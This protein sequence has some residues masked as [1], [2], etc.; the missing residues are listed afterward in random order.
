M[1]A[2]GL[3]LLRSWC[4]WRRARWLV[5]GAVAPIGLLACIARSLERPNIGVSQVVYQSIAIS[6]NRD[7]DILFLVDKSPTMADEQQSL[8]DNF[9]RF[10]EVLESIE[11]GLPNVHIGVITQDIGAGGFDSGGTCSG[12]GDAGRLQNTPRVAGCSPPAGAFIEDIA[13]PDGTRQRNYTGTLSDTF[14]CIAQVGPDGCGFEQHLESLKRALD[15]SVPENAGFL[16]PDAYLGIIILSDE[17]DCSAFDANVFAPIDGTV[18][19]PLGPLSDFRCA[20]F[21]WTCDGGPVARAPAVYASCVPRQDS[22]FLNHPQA[23][24][25]FVKDLKI[26]PGLIM[27]ATIIGDNSRFEIGL[28][29]DQRMNPEV[30]PSC[31]TATQ[32]A[33]PMPRVRYFADQFANLATIASICAADFSQSLILIAQRLASIIGNRCLASQT[34]TTD[35]DPNQPGL[36]LDCSALEVRALDSGRSEETLVPRCTMADATT[37]AADAPSP[38]WYVVPDAANCAAAPGQLSIRIHPPDRLPPPR[39]RLALQC[40]G[41]GSTQ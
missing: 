17:D 38:C 7:L 8:A 36:Q 20:E 11:G 9:P 10:I 25:D 27:V 24:A 6:Q 16:R 37:P 30:K 5:L 28:T 18:S 4:T 2:R 32:T 23:Y 22:P 33:E 34:A 29:T 13:N 19:D 41:A 15:D 40:V 26:D 1:I 39:S 21:G 14:G 31:M 12:A 35:V 3:Q